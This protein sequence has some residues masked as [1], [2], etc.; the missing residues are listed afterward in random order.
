MKI[1]HIVIPTIAVFVWGLGD[2][3]AT[4]SLI[5]STW[6]QTIVMPPWMYDFLLEKIWISTSIILT[7]IVVVNAWNTLRRDRRFRWIIGLFS[8]N[9]VLYIAWNYLFFNQHAVGIAALVS[10]LLSGTVIVTFFLIL[11]SSKRIPFLLFPYIWWT[12]FVSYTSCGIAKL[13]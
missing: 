13:L 8:T 5:N 1:N 9:A 2:L 7:T 11:P 3:I 10:V 12:L 4:T 6:Y